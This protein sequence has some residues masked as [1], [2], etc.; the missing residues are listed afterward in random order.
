MSAEIRVLS[1][2]WMLFAAVIVEKIAI[3]VI[4]E[5][6][7]QAITERRVEQFLRTFLKQQHDADQD[8]SNMD[9]NQLRTLLGDA[10]QGLLESDAIMAFAPI[11]RYTS[12]LFPKHVYAGFPRSWWVNV[13]VRCGILA[14]ARTVDYYDKT[15]RWLQDFP[16]SLER[17]EDEGPC[18]QQQQQQVTNFRTRAASRH[19]SDDAMFF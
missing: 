6:A 19:S 13:G 7:C 5:S 8:A 17:D 3:Y 11:G 18:E 9:L 16:I 1:G 10:S 14:D 4:T 2:F 15:G 12:V